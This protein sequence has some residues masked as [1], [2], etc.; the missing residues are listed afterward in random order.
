MQVFSKNG[1]TCNEFK[2]VEHLASCCFK[3]KLTKNKVN[4]V[5]EQDYEGVENMETS[6]SDS[7]IFL[8]RSINKISQL[9]DPENRNLHDIKINGR[10]IE[11]LLD[12]GSPISFMPKKMSKWILPVE[13]MHLPKERKFVDINQNC[14]KQ[15]DLAVAT[16][17]CVRPCPAGLRHFLLLGKVA[18][19]QGDFT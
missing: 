9:E 5:Q 19:A 11:V 1:K 16:P 8:I 3:K 2:K 13:R 10:S 4:R 15:L 12:A 7:S 14:S 18:L 6:S 17:L